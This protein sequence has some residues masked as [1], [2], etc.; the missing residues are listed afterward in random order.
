MGH[1]CLFEYEA[2]A[3]HVEPLADHERILHAALFHERR[4]ALSA[5][6]R[7]FGIVIDDDGLALNAFAHAEPVGHDVGFGV[8][9]LAAAGD[10]NRGRAFGAVESECVI[11]TVLQRVAG[12]AA[13][14]HGGAENH[15]AIGVLIALS[16]RGET[17][18]SP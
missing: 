15:N 17:K 11:E 5:V 4:N 16:T 1:A 7:S 18:A 6:A 10:D 8:A 13:F 12:S 3:G 2:A 14:A 9:A